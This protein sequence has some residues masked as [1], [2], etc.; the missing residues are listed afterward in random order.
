MKEFRSLYIIGNGFDLHHGIPSRYGQFGEWLLENHR[1]IHTSVTEYL[2]IE[3]DASWNR[4]EEYLGYFDEDSVREMASNFL[5]SYGADDWSDANHHDYQY[6]I[7]QVVQNLSSR[8]LDAFQEWIN[9]LRIPTRDECRN[10]LID[11]DTEAHFISFNYTPTLSQIY[12]VPESNIIYIHGVREDE[13]IVLGHDWVQPEEKE[14]T[15]EDIENLDVRIQEG[16]SIL[17]SY[18]TTTF[19]PSDRIIEENQSYF[20]SLTNT[21]HIYVLGHSLGSVDRGYFYEIIKRIDISNT[22]WTIS[23]YGQ[24]DLESKQSAITEFRIPESLVEFIELGRLVRE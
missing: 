6:E 24:A 19:K 7:E 18:F 17:R 5:I 12:A 2:H 22:R 15:Q 13:N 20:D 9:T 11:L 4:F 14:L 23:Y 1:N 10:L 21:R 8:L 3:D 16:E